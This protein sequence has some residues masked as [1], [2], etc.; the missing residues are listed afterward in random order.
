MDN[1]NVIWS[2][3]GLHV[4]DDTCVDVRATNAAIVLGQL[5]KAWLHDLHLS[6]DSA[7]WLAEQLIHAAEERDRVHVS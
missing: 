4:N 7:R 6:S 1:A 2:S 3:E 5:G